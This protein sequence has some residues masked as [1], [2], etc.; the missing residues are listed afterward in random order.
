MERLEGEIESLRRDVAGLSEQTHVLATQV[1][2][3]HIDAGRF[4]HQIIYTD[5]YRHLHPADLVRLKNGEILLFTREGTEHI[6]ND[7]DVIL[8]RSTDGGRTWGRKEVV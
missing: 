6:A 1:Y 3:D 4:Q 2:R 8:V 7:G 5:G